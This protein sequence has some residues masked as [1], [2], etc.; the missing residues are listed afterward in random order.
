M[1][2]RSLTKNCRIWIRIHQSEV[3]IRGSGPVPKFHGSATLG[4]SIFLPNHWSLVYLMIYAYLG[5]IGIQTDL[6]LSR[7]LRANLEIRKK[8]CNTIILIMNYTYMI[9]MC[10]KD[11]S[12]FL[13]LMLKK[14]PTHSKYLVSCEHSIF[15]VLIYRLNESGCI[16]LSSTWRT[17]LI[18]NK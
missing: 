17:G 3:C 9:Y 5:I 7:N 16:V 15:L 4:L 13:P 10:F 12:H 8:T 18:V 6:I 1:S 14:I 11:H 2:W